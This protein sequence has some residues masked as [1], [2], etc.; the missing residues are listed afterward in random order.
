MSE[1]NQSPKVT[2]RTSRKTLMKIDELVQ[3]KLFKTRSAFLNLAIDE[4][5]KHYQEYEES[6]DDGTEHDATEDLPAYI[7]TQREMELG[8]DNRGEPLD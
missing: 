8:S 4:L 6:W 1:A 5:L 7:E 3:K 2:F